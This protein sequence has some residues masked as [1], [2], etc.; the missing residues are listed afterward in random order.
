MQSQCS[1]PAVSEVKP[2]SRV[3]LLATARTAASQAPLTMGFSRQEYSSGVPFP[4]P[5]VGYKSPRIASSA[6]YTQ[7]SV[8][9]TAR[10]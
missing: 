4:P 5:I 10:T 9:L 6:C 7:Y 3:R 1:F 8:L 2:L